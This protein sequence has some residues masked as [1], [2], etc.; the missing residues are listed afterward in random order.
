MIGMRMN[1]LRMIGGED[2]CDDLWDDWDEDLD[3]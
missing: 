3:P 2:Y 1:G